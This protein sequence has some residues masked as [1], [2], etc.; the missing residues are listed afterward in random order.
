MLSGR[1]AV[2]AQVL[3]DF[4]VDRLVATSPDS[5][6]ILGAAGLH[7][8]SRNRRHVTRGRVTSVTQ[9]RYRSH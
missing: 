6:R 2:V 3:R 1:C 4:R 9:P 7:E 8:Q 5:I